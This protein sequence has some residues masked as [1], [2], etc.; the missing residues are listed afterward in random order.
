MRRMVCAVR[1]AVPYEVWRMKIAAIA[2]TASA[3]AIGGQ[4]FPPASDGSE[5]MPR[6]V[7]SLP[8]QGW[9]YAGTETRTERL[10][11]PRARRGETPAP[12]PAPTEA[13]TEQATLF[14]REVT[15]RPTGLVE[16]WVRFELRDRLP[17]I[18][19][20]SVVTLAE[21]DCVQNT[22]RLTGTRFY[23]GPAMTGTVETTATWEYQPKIP[24]PWEVSGRLQKL[25][26]AA[27][28]PPTGNPPGGGHVLRGIP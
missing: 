24:S 4:S 26:C 28:P 15:R 16:A 7:S 9:I 5:A 8:R 12:S 19:F 3:L 20:R 22:R 14:Y 18:P 6:W 11:V 2:L 27:A 1:G 17:V 13:S 23:S 21:F 25:V 10:P